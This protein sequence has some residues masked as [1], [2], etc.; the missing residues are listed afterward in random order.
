MVGM[1]RQG[2]P[3]CGDRVAKTGH[4]RA[5][6]D[7]ENPE[8]PYILMRARGTRAGEN[9][10]ILKGVLMMTAQWRASTG[11]VEPGIRAKEGLSCGKHTPLAEDGWNR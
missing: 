2:R 10:L 8:R 9:N 6:A 4:G 1:D 7:R 5:C 11:G 3:V